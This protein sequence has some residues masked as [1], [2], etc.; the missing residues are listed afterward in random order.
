[1]AWQT[2]A[3]RLRHMLCPWPSDG[4]PGHDWYVI[5]ADLEGLLNLKVNPGAA[6]TTGLGI[7]A[8]FVSILITAVG[9]PP[10]K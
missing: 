5:L 1:V 3:R 9:M 6:F 8:P 10:P 7:L 2:K 4:V